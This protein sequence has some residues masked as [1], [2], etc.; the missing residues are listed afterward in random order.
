MPIKKGKKEGGGFADKG[1]AGPVVSSLVFSYARPL[2]RKGRG[3]E[4]LRRGRKKVV[5]DLRRS[6]RR[7]RPE[8]KGKKRRG[9]NDCIGGGRGRV[10]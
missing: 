5:L 3:E 6:P 8:G 10:G 7:R 9:R 2:L 4:K 1:E